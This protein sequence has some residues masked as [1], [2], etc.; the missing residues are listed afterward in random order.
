M[1]YILPNFFHNKQE[2]YNNPEPIQKPSPPNLK[3]SKSVHPYQIPLY[4]KYSIFGILTFIVTYP[5]TIYQKIRII[6]RIETSN[7]TF[8]FKIV[9]M[10]DRYR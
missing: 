9:R 5:I 3:P 8:R 10:I 2:K 4:F 7:D 6:A 1:E